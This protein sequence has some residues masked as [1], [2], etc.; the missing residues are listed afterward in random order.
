[1]LP[2]D[3]MADLALRVDLLVGANYFW[4]I[5]GGNKKI[6]LPSGL[7]ILPSKFEYITTGRCPESNH[8]REGNPSA[9]F[10]A[11]RLDQDTPCVQ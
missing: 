7:F 11:A 1:M 3:K 5:E 8:V 4:D 10:V 6:I 9:L 2:N